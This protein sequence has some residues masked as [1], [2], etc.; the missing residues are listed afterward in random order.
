MLSAIRE[1][2]LFFFESIQ[3]RRFLMIFASMIVMF[4]II[5]PFGTFQSLTLLE[6]F[7]YW[8]LTMIGSW[9][10]AIITISFLVGLVRDHT[11]HHFSIIMGGCI[12][13]A[14]PIALYLDVVIHW[15]FPMETE[16]SFLYQLAYAMPISVTFGLL[17]HFAL[18]KEKV[19]TPPLV[20]EAENLLMHRLPHSKR[21]PVQYLSMQDHYVQVTTN[22]GNEL[23]LMRMADAV[24]ALKGQNGQQIHRSHWI[25]H[26]HVAEAIRENGQH[27]IIMSDGAKLPVSRTYLK[28]AKASGIIKA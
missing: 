15:Y 5:G 18:D 22:K 24:T 20:D 16:L 7:A 3:N 8:S 6:R 12:L 27:I 10:I 11:K 4:S 25:S 28:A 1:I 17:V 14:F 9:F 19:Q 13:S 26:D 23:V 2:P 21:G